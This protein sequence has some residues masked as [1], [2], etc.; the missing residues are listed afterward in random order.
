MFK[1]IERLFNGSNE[2]E[3][4]KMR[5]VVEEQINPLEAS[6]KNLSDASLAHKTVEFKNR[7]ANG[8][9][10]DDILPEAFAVVR[11]ASRRV[12]GMRQYDVQLIGG[13]VLHSGNIA[14]MCTGE[15]KTL[16]AVAPVYL[17]ALEGKGAHVITV[18]DYLAKRDSEWMGQV[19]KFLGLSVGLIVHDLDFDQR[20]IAYNSD[21]TYGTNNEFGFD[22]LRDNM[23]TR[24][25]QMVQRPLHYCLIDE[26]DSILIDEAR[27][28]LIISGPGQ[29]STDMYYTVAKLVPKLEKDVDYTIDEKQ[30]TVAPTEAGVA[31]MEKLLHVDNLYDTKN[32]ELN[33][34][35]NQALRAETMMKRDRDYVVKDGEVIIVDEFTGRMMYGRRYSDGLHQAIEAKEGCKVERES[36]TLATITFQNYFR[37]YDKL[38]GMTGTAKTEEQEFIK[39]YGLEVFQI[40]TN[41]PIRRVDLPDAIYKT[42]RGKIRAVVR[43]VKR[44]HA[45]GQPILIGTTSIEQ[46]EELSHYLK[47][48]GIVHN[49][50]NA[51]YHEKE[52]MIVAQAGQKGQVTI[53]TNMAGR[54]TDIVLGDGVA[55]LGGL[56]IIGTERHESRRIDN[57][58]RGRAGRQ[59]D[60]GG[61]QFFLSLDDD[62]LRIFGGDN[63]KKFMEKMGLDEDEEIKSK[64]VSNAIRKA[65]Q[66]V[67][68][69][70]FETRKYVLEYDDVMNQQRQVLYEQ[71][72]R[73]LEGEDMKDQIIRMV[74]ELINHAMNTYADEKLYPE[75]WDLAGLIKYCEKYFLVP[76]EI[77]VKQIEDMSREEIQKLLVKTAHDTYESR[78]KSIGSELMRELEKAVMLKVVDAKWMEHLDNMDML[79]EGIN[80]R[81]YGQRNP[82]VEYKV[83]AFD[84]FEEM[85]HIIMETIILY[86]YH[87]QIRVTEPVQAPATEDHLK[88][89][90]AHYVDDNTNESVAENN[91]D[92]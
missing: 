90:T 21:V 79:K 77:T 4:K 81:S 86:M 15:G 36:Q 38:A 91:I 35:F 58:L 63:I 80:L 75:E 2:R 13:M 18:N 62:L 73:I 83:E 78:E 92:H 46:S 5:R 70:N 42:K 24:L 32:L 28:P 12:L 25:D 41:K 71:R 44:R 85:E 68:N 57:Q 84:M 22:Y 1:F 11:E 20:K 89:S 37:M 69:R 8:E 52:A 31:K 64:M 3:I 17:N 45:T 76:G 6:L 14:E 48:E 34:I 55:E 59:G 87:I 23:V 7:L 16:V 49:V 72:R 61:S 40:P 43:E 66:R 19:Y 65:Q 47:K 88:G 54:G 9:T 26:V 50:L 67:E 29:K 60:P 51:K 27:T 10:L 30:K 82:I 74:D 53:A 39:I 33:H 56:A